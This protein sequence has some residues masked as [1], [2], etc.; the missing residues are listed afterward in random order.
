M[1]PSTI[2]AVIEEVDLRIAKLQATKEVLQSLLIADDTRAVL[3]RLKGQ[4]EQPAVK[5]K[6]S[7]ATR[8]RIAASARKRWRERRQAETGKKKTP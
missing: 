2:Q 7:E 3:K 6:M 5:R 4:E 1:N 8:R